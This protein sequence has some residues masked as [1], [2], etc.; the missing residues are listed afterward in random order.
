MLA[1]RPEAEP[2][3]SRISCHSRKQTSFLLVSCEARETKPL[4][5]TAGAL[6]AAGVKGRQGLFSGWAR[7]REG[8][9]F[10]VGRPGGLSLSL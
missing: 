9:S 4:G 2:I 5:A 10:T 7:W 6:G 3:R 8:R 1:W